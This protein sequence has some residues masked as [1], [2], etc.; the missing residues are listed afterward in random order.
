MPTQNLTEDVEFNTR[1]DGNGNL[2]RVA[3]FR[4]RLRNGVPGNARPAR[5][6]QAEL[7]K[8]AAR[9]SARR[10]VNEERRVVRAG[11]TQRRRN[12]A[13]PQ[14][15]RRGLRQRVANGL[16]AGAAVLRRRRERKNG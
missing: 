2:V 16:R 9:Q 5:A 15:Q 13:T 8:L 11:G 3:E 12:P 1:L 4:K 10:A 14:P 7:Q 6:R